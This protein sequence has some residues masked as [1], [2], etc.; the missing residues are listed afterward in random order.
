MSAVE[1]VVEG[2]REGAGFSARLRLE[3]IK[4][5]HVVYR[6]ILRWPLLSANPPQSV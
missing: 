4:W 5:R 6:D 2:W 1:G 3:P